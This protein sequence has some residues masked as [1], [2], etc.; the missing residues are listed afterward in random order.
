AEL[1]VSP[2]EVLIGWVGRLDPKKRVGDFI[3]AC[4]HVAAE[5]PNA[6]FVVIGGPD[7]FFPEYA[8]GLRAQAAALGLEGRLTFTGDRKDV[9]RLLSALDV[10]VWL[11]RGEGM[12]H[13]IAEAGAAGLPVVATRDGGTPQQ[14]RDGVS[15]LF[16]PHERPGAV[17]EA[18]RFL[19]DHP[20]VRARFGEALRAHVRRRYGAEVVV[21]QWERLFRRLAA[22]ELRPAPALELAAGPRTQL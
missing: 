10:F 6:R 17:A 19:V 4:A 18:V 7:A 15:G 16:V 12:P 14:I 22:R 20:D 9:P 21:P 8:D 11:S 3:Q 5:R 13:V 2:E 1:G